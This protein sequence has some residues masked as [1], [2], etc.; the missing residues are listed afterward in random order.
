MA[1]LEQEIA[2]E[3][4]AVVKGAM[5][6]AKVDIAADGQIDPASEPEEWAALPPQEKSFAR[7]M[8]KVGWMKSSEVPHGVK[9]AQAMLHGLMRSSAERTVSQVA[10]NIQPAAFPVPVIEV[11]VD[12]EPS[13]SPG[14]YEVIDE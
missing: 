3:T 11:K 6:F 9:M 4:A 12:G 1:S 2:Q 13:A 7:R 8:A 14:E 5:G 10:I